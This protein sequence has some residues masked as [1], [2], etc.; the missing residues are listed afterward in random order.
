MAMTHAKLAID[1]CPFNCPLYDGDPCYSE[2]MAPRS[3]DLLGRSVH[4]NVS[5]LLT[6]AD[7]DQIAEGINKVLAALL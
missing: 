6:E 4:I 3:L 2:D 5:P 7:A 1:G